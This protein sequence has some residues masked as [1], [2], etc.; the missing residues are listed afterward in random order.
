MPDHYDTIPTML[1][2]IVKYLMKGEIT[3]RAHTLQGLESA[4]EDIG[5]PFSGGNTDKLLVDL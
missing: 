5:L 1:Q 4:I 3:Y 2:T